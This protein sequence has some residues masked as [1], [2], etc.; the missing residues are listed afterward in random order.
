M[1]SEARAGSQRLAEAHTGSHRSAEADFEHTMAKI[2][3]KHTEH[4]FDS[5]IK[6]IAMGLDAFR[7]EE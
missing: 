7:S 3:L 1:R 4:D 2:A 6:I 5:P